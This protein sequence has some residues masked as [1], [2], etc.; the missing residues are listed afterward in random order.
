MG[1]PV[2]AVPGVE[3][4]TGSLGHGLP[5]ANGF[6]L[7][8]RDRPVY[9]ILGDGELQEGSVWEAAMSSSDLG[10]D[11]LTAIID[12]NGLQITGST[13]ET[14]RLE[15][16]DARWRAFG[17]AVHEVDGHDLGALKHALAKRA[18]GRPTMII[19]RTIKGHGLPSVQGRVESHFT[20]LGER[21][22]TRAIAVL[23]ARAKRRNQ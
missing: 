1:H 21:Q 19:A 4:P 3:M 22:H 9:V 17:W 7:A 13:E 20:R 12:R 16:L 15:P 14:V 8:D 23:R 10:L 5:L 2:R 6:A 11:N 18:K